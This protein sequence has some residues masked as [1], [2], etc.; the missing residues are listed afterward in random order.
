M[1]GDLLCAVP[2]LRAFRRAFPDAEITLFGLPWSSSFALRFPHLVDGFLA[3]PGFPGLPEGDPDPAALARVV[4]EARRRRFDLAV[5]LH[6]SGR[7]SNALASRLGARR[8]AGFH[9]GGSP[10]PDPA[11]FVAWPEEGHEIHRL[12]RLPEGLGL[13]LDGD[14]LEFPL[15]E[16]D[17]A[18]LARSAPGLEPG[19]YAVVHPGAR[20]ARRWAAAR[21]AEVAD[22]LAVRGL[23]ICLSGSDEERRV[24]AAVARAMR[25]RPRDLAGRTSLGALG[26]LVAGARIVVAND[27]GISHVAAALGTPS[28]VVATT[29]EPARWAPLDRDRH[30]VLVRPAPEPVVA[31]AADLLAA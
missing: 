17:A 22:A 10:A 16:A 19:G 18:E 12:L 25:T 3:V 20:S 8:L 14:R 4:G 28:V 27:T 21:F 15:G 2:A 30:R 13:R 6:G 23:E 31:E 26:A 1:L 29:S 11:L 7:V 24:T 9:P 5:Q